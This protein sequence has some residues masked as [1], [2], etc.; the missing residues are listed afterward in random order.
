[1]TATMTSH[2]DISISLSRGAVVSLSDVRWLQ[3]AGLIVSVRSDERYG[4]ES[5]LSVKR[6]SIRT[7]VVS[8]TLLLTSSIDSLCE[9]QQVGYS[10]G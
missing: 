6:W 10:N 4:S 2:H 1:M 8:V 3:S 5:G 9:R 7:A